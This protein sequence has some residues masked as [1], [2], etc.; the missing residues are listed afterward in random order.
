MQASSIGINSLFTK[1]PLL[2][3]QSELYLCEAIAFIT[4]SST[5]SNPSNNN[6]HSNEDKYVLGD[7]IAIQTNQIQIALNL[8]DHQPHL[9]E[10]LC[11]EITQRINALCGLTKGYNYKTHE[12]KIE[13]FENATKVIV[14]IVKQLC[15]KHSSLRAKV[16]FFLHRMVHCMG[17]RIIIYDQE[18][19]PILLQTHQTQDNSFYT[20]NTTAT[21]TD[22]NNEIIGTPNEIIQIVNQLMMEFGSDCE[23]TVD[24]LFSLIINKYRS[25]SVV[26][27]STVTTTTNTT[28]SFNLEAPHIQAERLALLHQYLLF[29][30]H[31][32]CYQCLSVLYS[33]RNVHELDGMF[34]VILSG[35]SGG[36]VTCN[37]Q[38]SVPVRKTSLIILH[39]LILYWLL[40]RSYLNNSTT[41]SSST[42]Y[43]DI[44]VV[45]DQIKSAFR[46]YLY[47]N[48]IPTAFHTISSNITTT[49]ISS[50]RS[51]SSSEQIN[52]KED[53]RQINV[54]DVATQSILIELS[55]LFRYSFQELEYSSN[56]NNNQNGYIYYENLCNNL[57]QWPI[58]VIK[59]LL[60]LVVQENA[61]PLGTFKETFK[62]FIR[63]NSIN[64]IT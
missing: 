26:L 33:Q 17:K 11:I 37:T 19:I 29:I 53:L 36:F 23:Q 56:N 44:V 46:S 31:I 39:N 43:Y 7:L 6:H 63:N 12:N 4:S 42:C 15:V 41:S 49:V 61:T 9:Q 27:E 14:L 50:N 40:P 62:K 47:E 13:Y 64:K 54:N 5:S 35:L 55:V 1:P 16:L 59:S 34:A 25:L 10:Q 18:I 20:T 58:E 8:Y 3:E 28:T 57:L 21:I 51:S 52:R 22:T 2:S 24:L 38:D 60:V 30:Q 32:V 48:A 45:P